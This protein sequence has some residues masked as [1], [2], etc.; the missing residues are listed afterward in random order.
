MTIISF[1]CVAKLEKVLLAAVYKNAAYVS[2]H[3]LHLYKKQMEKSLPTKYKSLKT[4]LND[5]FIDPVV[6]KSSMILL[7]EEFKIRQLRVYGRGPESNFSLVQQYE[8]FFDQCSVLERLA[9][10]SK[11]L[12]AK[13]FA[14]CGLPELPLEHKSSLSEEEMEKDSKNGESAYSYDDDIDCTDADEDNW[15]KNWN[16]S[17][18]ME[19]IA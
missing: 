8:V 12:S 10:Y 18:K 19:V 11:I 2:C 3:K 16:P 14:E 17:K 13:G 9:I 1:L 6:L 15:L 4:I 5:L 7:P